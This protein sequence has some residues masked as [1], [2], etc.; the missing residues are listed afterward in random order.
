M[1]SLAPE[2]EHA[3]GGR[4]CFVSEMAWHGLALPSTPGPGAGGSDGSDGCP[5]IGRRI[6]SMPRMRE[7]LGRCDAR[8]GCF[9]CIAS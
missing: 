1:E 7:G 2:S 8:V 6:G 9:G 5:R 4:A 3:V